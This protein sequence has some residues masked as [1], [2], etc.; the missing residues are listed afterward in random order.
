MRVS[1]AWPSSRAP[2]VDLVGHGRGD[3]SGASGPESSGFWG[4][5]GGRP[6]AGAVDTESGAA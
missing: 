3:E 6:E 5:T 1:D 4:K 2:D